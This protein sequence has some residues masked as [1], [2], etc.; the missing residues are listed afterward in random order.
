MKPV[1]LTLL[2]AALSLPFAAQADREND[3]YCREFTRDV[4]IGGKHEQAY[5][6]ACRQPDG[7]WQIVGDDE[8]ADFEDD[9]DDLYR[10]RDRDE[11]VIVRS[12][13]VY[14]PSFGFNIL[15][16]DYRYPHHRYYYG[17][18]YWRGGKWLRAAQRE[19]K[20]RWRERGNGNSY[21]HLVTKSR[22]R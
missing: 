2:L 18:S 14:V 13:R 7:S 21:S 15:L 17:D 5:G 20:Q 16:G 1:M 19:H 12:E 8:L 9:D 22:N 6:I 11:R 4:K 3:R 10:R